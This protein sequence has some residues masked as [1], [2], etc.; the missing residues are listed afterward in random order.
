[1]DLKT[2]CKIIKDKGLFLFEFF[3]LTKSDQK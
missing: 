3:I 2:S 1:M